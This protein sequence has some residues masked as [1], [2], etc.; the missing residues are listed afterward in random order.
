MQRERER[1]RERVVSGLMKELPK[2]IIV[3]SDATLPAVAE[4]E[5]LDFWANQ[6]AGVD[7]GEVVVLRDPGGWDCFTPKAEVADLL[8]KGFTVAEKTE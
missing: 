3:T 7:V 5:M 6:F 4:A 1:E 8:A 2:P